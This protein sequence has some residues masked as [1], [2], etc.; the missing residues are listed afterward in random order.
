VCV[1]NLLALRFNIAL[2]GKILPMGVLLK[3]GRPS[4]V[5]TQ[6]YVD[7]FNRIIYFLIDDIFNR[8]LIIFLIAFLSFLFN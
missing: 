4:H 7:I 8:I 6:Y 3:V 2:I 5:S 1:C